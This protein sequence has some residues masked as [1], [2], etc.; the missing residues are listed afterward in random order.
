MD[1]TIYSLEQPDLSYFES[2]R[3]G[4]ARWW[5]A[6]GETP[7]FEGS[8]FL[9]VGCGHGSLCVD[10]ASKGARRVVGVDIDE[11]RIRF[12]TQNV[13]VNYLHLQNS[14]EFRCGDVDGLPDEEIFD[15]IC[16]KDTFEHILQPKKV[17]E[18]MK[19]RLKIGGKML[20]GFGPL[21]NSPY[22][23]HGRIHSCLPVPYGH[24]MIPESW[25]VTRINRRRTEKI[26][27]VHE[28][29]LNKLSFREYEDLFYNSGLCVSRFC[30][31]RGESLITKAFSLIRHIPF[32]R[33]YFTINMYCILE[34]V[35]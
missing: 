35:R 7:C 2:G 24:L 31:N 33:E 8:T 26:L 15:F 13:M 28:L 16:S 23:G 21:W 5:S 25:L 34:K 3:L 4:N 10:I 18:A 6:F 22:G 9:D 27:S 29:G 17:L 30:V 20:I 11:K 32:L 12:A 19:R 14:L 1:K